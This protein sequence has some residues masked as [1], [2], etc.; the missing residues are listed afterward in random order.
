MLLTQR[1]PTPEEVEIIQR[2]HDLVTDWIYGGDLYDIRRH[3]T[4]KERFTAARFTPPSHPMFPDLHRALDALIASD[5]IGDDGYNY[6][7]KHGVI[8]DREIRHAGG[9]MR[10][11]QS[12]AIKIEFPIR[13]VNGED[14]FR[15]DHPERAEWFVTSPN[16]SGDV[17]HRVPHMQTAMNV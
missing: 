4:G 11:T 1:D 3:S 5:P 16:E 12:G 10:R 2:V 9:R 8:T 6:A 17:A 13:R 7:T 14:V 15:S